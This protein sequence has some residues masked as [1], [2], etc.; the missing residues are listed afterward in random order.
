MD[1]RAVAP[2]DRTAWAALFADYG[3]FYEAIFDERVLDG[4]WSWLMDDSHGVSALVAVRGGSIVGFAH[5]QRLADTFT[6]GPSWFLDD[7]YVSP[8]ARGTGAATALIDGVAEIA[9][10]RGGGTL[11]WITAAENTRAQSVY[12][13]VARRTSWVTFEKET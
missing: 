8:D 4:V 11:R 7:L 10:A 3:V 5:Y 1:V 2:P 12:D 6:A 13:R 9:A